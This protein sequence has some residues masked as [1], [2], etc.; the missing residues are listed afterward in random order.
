MYCIIKPSRIP[1]HN[2]KRWSLGWWKMLLA[3]AQKKWWKNRR[4]IHFWIANMD[5][6]VRNVGSA[7]CM[8]F[9]Q[10]GSGRWKRLPCFAYSR[11]F[12]VLETVLFASV[13]RTTTHMAV[14]NI[15]FPFSLVIFLSSC[16]NVSTTGS[17][18]VTW[19]FAIQADNPFPM[20]EPRDPYATLIADFRCR[21]SLFTSFKSVDIWKHSTSQRVSASKEVTAKHC[22]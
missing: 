10:G 4:Y 2:S 21:L 18:T 9:P 3:R 15:I 11:L 22:I 13:R 19:V 7:M 14:Q 20:A 12:H 5:S 6:F 16:T 8:L 17:C 1:K